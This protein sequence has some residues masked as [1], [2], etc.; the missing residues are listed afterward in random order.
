MN[1]GYMLFMS[2]MMIAF[3]AMIIAYVRMLLFFNR[4]KQPDE[5]SFDP[6]TGLNQWKRLLTSGGFG[7]E[8]EPTRRGVI[9]T[10][11]FAIGL[12][13]LAIILFLTLP[14]MPV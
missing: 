7:P 5:S 4:Q 9:R 1:P 10:Y 13:L 12:F 8:A 2:C 14:G 6:M 3:F 11:I